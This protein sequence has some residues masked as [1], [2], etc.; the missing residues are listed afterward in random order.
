MAQSLTNQS[1]QT[2]FDLIRDQFPA[3]KEKVFLDAACVSLA[4]CRATEAIQK[5]MDVALLC[6]E[7][8]STLHHIAMDEMRAEARPQI[9]RLINAREDERSESCWLSLPRPKSVADS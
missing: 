2:N 4:P 9:A 7:R 3:L 5:F 8:S 6:P 1:S